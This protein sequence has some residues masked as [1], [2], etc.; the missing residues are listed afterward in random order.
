MQIFS[1]SFPKKISFVEAKYN[2]NH[3][4]KFFLSSFSLLLFFLQET[5]MLLSQ[6]SSHLYTEVGC[7]F[8]FY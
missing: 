5:D 1:S 6:Y 8:C 4:G 2:V 3:Y 7:F